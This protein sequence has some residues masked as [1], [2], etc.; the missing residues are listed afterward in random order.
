MAWVTALAPSASLFAQSPGV[1][2]VRQR[3]EGGIETGETPEQPPAAAEPTAPAISAVPLG[4]GIDTAFVSPAAV[5]V[6]VL[7]PSQLLKSPIAQMLPT[8]VATA[9]GMQYLGFDPADVEQVVAFVEMPAGFGPPNYG[10]TF[11]FDQPFKASQIPEQYRAAA[12][13]AELNGKK[14]L[15]SAHPVFPSFYGSNSRTLVVAPDAML[16]QLVEAQNEKASSPLLDRMRQAPSNGDLYIGV[17]LVTLRPLIGMGLASAQ[18]PPDAQPFLELPGQLSALEVGANISGKGPTFVLAHAND[19]AAAEQVLAVLNEA[20]QRQQQTLKAQFAEQAA[21][22]DPI[23]RAFA[24]YAERASTQW[25]QNFMPTREGA[26]ITLFRNNGLDE[27]QKKILLGAV[28]IS[29]SLMLP[30]VQAARTAARRSQSMNNLK[31][32]VLALLNHESAT[33][34]LPAHAIYSEDGAPLLSWRVK[35]L[36]FIDGGQELYAQFH[37]DEPWDSEHNRAL[38]PQMPA[39]F[40]SPSVNLEPGK[41][42]YLAVVGPE[43]IFDGTKDGTSFRSITDGTSKT[44]IVVEADPSRA[45]EWTRP[46]DLT[47]NLDDPKQGL[48]NVFPQGWNAAFCDGSVQFISD[49]ID[50]QVLRAMFTR[51]GGEVINNQ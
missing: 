29:A 40:A 14:Y 38:I 41:T 32:I 18:L 50:P 8:E 22:E 28:G 33:K 16:R 35:I 24:Q 48:G 1:Q 43:C 23:E 21:S 12:Q 44:I 46:D 42:N 15:Q 45:V 49:Q 7:R 4:D 10:I 30:A 20:N 6:V 13:L 19:E 11:L 9:A 36:P 5:A 26:A 37:L 25:S 31:Q 3:F 17:D 27:S 51:A 34:T 39:A 47:V 2:A